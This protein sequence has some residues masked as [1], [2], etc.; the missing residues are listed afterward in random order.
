MPFSTFDNFQ[1]QIMIYLPI[2][3]HL[4][5]ILE[6]SDKGDSQLSDVRYVGEDCI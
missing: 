3:S 4:K 6:T 1:D 5:S 2:L